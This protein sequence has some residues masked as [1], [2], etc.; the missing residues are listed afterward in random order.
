LR[1]WQRKS[2]LLVSRDPKETGVV[3]LRGGLAE[4]SGRRLLLGNLLA[5]KLG[6][7]QVVSYTN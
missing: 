6:G 3:L 4:K 7:L 5:A 1:A 2:A